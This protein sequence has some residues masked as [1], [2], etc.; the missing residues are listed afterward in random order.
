[1]RLMGVIEEVYCKKPNEELKKSRTGAP[2]SNKVV[3][4]SIN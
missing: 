2:S 1:M 4:I 3:L